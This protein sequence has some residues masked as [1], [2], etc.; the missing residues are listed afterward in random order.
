ML[1]QHQ[2]INNNIFKVNLSLT[3]YQTGLQSN[4]TNR[5]CLKVFRG[6]CLVVAMVFNIL[7]AEREDNSF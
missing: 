2:S 5:F 3:K 4:G 7:T 1:A 6:L